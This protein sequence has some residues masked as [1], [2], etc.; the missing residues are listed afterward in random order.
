MI[1]GP[2]IAPI[3]DIFMDEFIILGKTKPINQ[4]IAGL[5]DALA[6]VALHQSRPHLK[7]SL[8]LEEPPSK[9]H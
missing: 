6:Q 1:A 5:N 7:A 2:V 4:I 3:E 8:W 9:S